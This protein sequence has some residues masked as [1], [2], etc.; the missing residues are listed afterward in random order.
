MEW[1]FSP[2]DPS[3][4]H[5]ISAGISWHARLMLLAWG[6]LAPAAILG[7]RF[8]KITPRQDWPRVL[9][10]P[11]WWRTH[12]MTQSLVIFLS[13]IGL[14]IIILTALAQSEAG[15]HQWLG[16]TVLVSGVFQ[17]LSGYFRGSKGGPANRISDD[18]RSGD[19]YNMTP[20]RLAFETVHKSIGYLVLPVAAVAIISGLWS[21][22]GAVWMWVTIFGWWVFL[23]VVSLHLQAR[24]YAV[25]TYQAIWGPDPHHPGNQMKPQGWKARRRNAPPPR[26]GG[27]GS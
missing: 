14:A 4:A 15:L 17:G 11:F 18:V 2:I 24:G 21:V 3:R 23:I 27:Q 13:V 19:H 10:N 16:Y 6:I 22:N 5:L 9:D 20:W 12:W 26:G 8:F 25:D 1:L 7:A